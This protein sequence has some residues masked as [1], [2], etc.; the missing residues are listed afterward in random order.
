MKSYIAIS[1]EVL[2]P[3]SGHHER[4]NEWV[5][6]AWHLK[7]LSWIVKPGRRH[8]WI[9]ANQLANLHRCLTPKLIQFDIRF[10]PKTIS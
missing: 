2:V 8:L 7:H 5:N 3:G 1:K 10:F 4:Q 6:N 9:P